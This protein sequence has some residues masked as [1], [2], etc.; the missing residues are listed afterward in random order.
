LSSS[1]RKPG[2]LTG[3]TDCDN[4][5][6][7]HAPPAALNAAPRALSIPTFVNRH[8]YG[9]GKIWELADVIASC[10]ADVP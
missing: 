3:T 9:Y 10:G 2:R 1:R 8:A 5:F 7:D 4:N 6:R